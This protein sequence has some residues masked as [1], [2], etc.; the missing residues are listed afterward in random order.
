M[1]IDTRSMLE[2]FAFLQPC[3]GCKPKYDAVVAGTSDEIY[4]CSACKE[5]YSKAVRRIFAEN[6]VFDA[7]Q[8]ALELEILW[9]E[10]AMGL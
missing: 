10:E 7:R 3:E 1:G 5:Q 2:A 6:E 9:F 4:M 8:L